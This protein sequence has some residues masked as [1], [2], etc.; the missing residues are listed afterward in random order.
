MTVRSIAFV[1]I[2]LAL[3]GCMQETLQPSTQANWNSRDKQLMTNLPYAQASIPE[4]YQQIGRA[5][6]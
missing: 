1:I 4:A 3:G 2:G 5:H 6:V